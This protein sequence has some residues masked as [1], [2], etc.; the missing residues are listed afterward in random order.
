MSK[1]VTTPVF[2]A[3]TRPIVQAMQIIDEFTAGQA[4]H[5]IIGAGFEVAWVGRGEE[6]GLRRE[7]ELDRSSG[8]TL[9]V[10]PPFL[11]ITKKAVGSV[12]IDMSDWIVI[13]ESMFDG[14]ISDHVFREKYTPVNG[15]KDHG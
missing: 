10:A 15:E 11:A 7:H 8:D 2:Y 1:K 12:R 3:E 14:R 6:H 4:C 9:G 13:S 5:Y